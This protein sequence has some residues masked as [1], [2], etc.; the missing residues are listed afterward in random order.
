M[1]REETTSSFTRSS[2][3]EGGT[4]LYEEQIVYQY[5]FKTTKPELCSIYEEGEGEIGPCLVQQK[6]ASE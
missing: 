6:Q 1:E 4:L 5:A 2:I 3:K